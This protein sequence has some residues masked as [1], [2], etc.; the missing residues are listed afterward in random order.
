MEA[1][2][3]IKMETPKP[4]FDNTNINVI[5]EMEVKKENEVYKIQFGIKENDLA[6][7]IVNY[8]S[9]NIYY[10]QSCY[11]MLELQSVSMAFSF[12]KTIKDI[13]SFLKNLKYQIEEKN[14]DLILKFNIF[15]PDGKSQII[16]LNLKKCLPDTNHLIKYLLEEIKTIKINNEIIRKK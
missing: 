2:E 6:I 4:S 16:E 5:E 1:A 8:N 10:Y 13:I 15:T 11:N 14:N 12:Y 9:E 3:P 7:K